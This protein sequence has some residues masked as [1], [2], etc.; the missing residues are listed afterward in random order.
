MGD[1]G[2]MGAALRD[3]RRERHAEWHEQNMAELRASGL[4]FVERETAV[5]F[6][7]VGKP[8]EVIERLAVRH[9]LADALPRAEVSHG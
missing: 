5:L 2:E 3:C 4:R 1:V 9:V 7:A 6:R 8:R